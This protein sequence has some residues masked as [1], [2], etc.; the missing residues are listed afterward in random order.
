MGTTNSKSSLAIASLVALAASA[1]TNS[2]VVDATRPFAA[3]AFVPKTRR[4]N[5]SSTARLILEIRGGEDATI[6]GESET[7]APTEEKSLDEKVYA[8]MEKLGLSVPSA[9][10]TTSEMDCEDGVCA[11]PGQKDDQQAQPDA[12]PV[13]IADRISEDMSIDSYMAMAA[14]GATSTIGGDGN[15]RIFN[16]SAARA[17]IQQ[18][19]DLIEMIPED[20]EAVQTLTGEGFQVF[21]SRR[22]LAFSE[23]NVDDARAILLAEQM[24]AEEEEQEEEAARA[25]AATTTVDDPLATSVETTEMKSA[26]FVEVKGANFDPTKISASAPAKAPVPATTSRPKDMPKPARKEDVVFEAT[27]EQIQ[28]LVLE[29]D[30]PV[31]LDIY[32]DW[33]DDLT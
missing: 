3:T 20:S 15:K 8:A 2:I 7:A 10:V 17:M 23:N 9:D 14:V 19:L 30:V 16:E 6:T 21:M 1:S 22:A 11:I 18:E 13:E 26:D 24:D 4:Q 32:A 31:L 25:A 12:D 29:S 5:L 27:T 28:E 33:Y